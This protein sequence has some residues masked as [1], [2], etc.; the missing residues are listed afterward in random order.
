MQIRDLI[1]QELVT[2]AVEDED[3]DFKLQVTAAWDEIIKSLNRI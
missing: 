3:L 2:P 1:N